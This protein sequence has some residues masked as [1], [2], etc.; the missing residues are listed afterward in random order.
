MYVEERES[1][2]RGSGVKI[3]FGG[4]FDGGKNCT[5]YLHV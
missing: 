4:G 3:N 2:R 1:K 5:E